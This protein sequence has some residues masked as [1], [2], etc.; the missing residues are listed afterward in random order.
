MRRFT[1]HRLLLSLAACAALYIAGSCALAVDQPA[2]GGIWKAVVPPTAMH[3]EFANEDPVGLAAGKHIKTDCSMNWVSGDD[4][5][6]YC[7]TTG[8]SLLFF[9]EAPQSYIRAARKFYEFD[10]PQT[11]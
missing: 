9:E 2:P 3:G 1:R 5:K 6:L 7:F 11:R 4:G 8:T 10:R